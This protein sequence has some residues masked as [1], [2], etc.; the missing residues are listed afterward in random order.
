MP[1]ANHKHST[2]SNK[3]DDEDYGV[4]LKNEK[5][6]RRIYPQKGKRPPKDEESYKIV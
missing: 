1:K 4:L 3:D 6:K 2:D 5:Y